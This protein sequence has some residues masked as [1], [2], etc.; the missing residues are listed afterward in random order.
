MIRLAAYNVENLFERAAAFNLPDAAES[1]AAALAHARVNAIL[2]KPRYLAADRR[3][4][5][6]HLAALGLARSDRSKIAILRQSRGRLRDRAGAITAAG[7]GDWVG[8]VE[9]LP[10]PVNAEAIANTGRVIQRLGA[11]ILAVVEAESR[12]ALLRF[13]RQV[14]K[15]S[16][17]YAHAML[18]DGN[19]ERGID[20]GLLTKRG[21]EICAMR[22]H[23]D[24][25][26]GRF[27]PVF[28]RDCPEYEVR[29]P[30]GRSLWVLPNHFS[31]KFGGAGADP[32]RAAQAARAAGIYRARRDSGAELVAVVGDLNDD[33]RRSVLDPLLKGTDLRDA[34][35]LPA[36]ES[37]GLPG[38]FGAGTAGTKIDYVL[39]SPALQALARRAGV[40]RSGV[41][42]SRTTP[43]W[44]MLPGMTEA[45]AASDHAAIWVDLDL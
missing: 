34:S 3:A 5:Q 18:V 20:V 24:A 31:S 36:W 16:P 4:I 44:E 15:G 28:A 13:V 23:V 42:D 33:P 14:L 11:D 39:L 27:D 17:D 10:E 1:R 29:L 22:S 30:S 6:A 38:T 9:L 41:F 40:E 43:R 25:R 7:R 19:D 21:L 8:Q 35:A 26:E 32:R 45:T 37:D 2:G 12:P